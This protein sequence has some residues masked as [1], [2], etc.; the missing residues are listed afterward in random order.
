MSSSRGLYNRIARS[1]KKN[2]EIEADLRDQGIRF[3]PP[4]LLG[5]VR[6]L[7]GGTSRGGFYAATLLKSQ[8]QP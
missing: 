7:Y 4:P 3:Y 1:L 6:E 8:P 5:N 2:R